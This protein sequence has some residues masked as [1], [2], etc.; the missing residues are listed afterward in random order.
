MDTHYQISE[1]HTIIFKKY[2]VSLKSGYL[3]QR[4]QHKENKKDTDVLDEVR[5]TITDT[6]K[7]ILISTMCSDGVTGKLEKLLKA[8]WQL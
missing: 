2:N 3:T 7:N 5:T 1:V 4:K 8:Q 6:R